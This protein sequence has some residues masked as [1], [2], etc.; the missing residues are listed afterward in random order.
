MV[1]SINKGRS[2]EVDKN[3]L[4]VTKHLSGGVLQLNKPT[5]I[6]WPIIEHLS[7]L[8]TGVAMIE[9]TSA[10]SSVAVLLIYSTR[11]IFLWQFWPWED[12]GGGYDVE[13]RCEL[14]KLILLIIAML[15]LF[16]DELLSN[17]ESAFALA[18]EYVGLIAAVAAPVI[19]KVVAACTVKSLTMASEN[20]L[21]Q[22]L[23]TQVGVSGSASQM[24]AGGSVDIELKE[25]W[26]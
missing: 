16:T 13:N 1:K 19:G 8:L 22:N 15:C 11:L 26:F 20:Y 10:A 23:E 2:H 4:S 5:S 25:D 24:E 18:Y 9:F 21:T 12:T 17:C 7:Q 6:V 14:G 3:T